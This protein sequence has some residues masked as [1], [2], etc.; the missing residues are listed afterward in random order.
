MVTKLDNCFFVLGTDTDV[1]KTYISS[2]LYKGLKKFGCGYFKAI[3]S[4]CYFENGKLIAPDV[5]EVCKKSDEDYNEDYILYR[6]KEAVS[7]HLA[8][9]MENIEIDVQKIKERY[10]L[11]KSKNNYL[12]VEGA[13][14]LLV[15]L[16]RDK[17]YIYDM[18]KLFDIPVILVCS[19]RVGAINHTLLTLE[20]LRNRGL[21]IQGIV[22]NRVNL[23]NNYEKDNIEIIKKLGR[24]ENTIIVREKQENII[25]EELINFLSYQS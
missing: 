4:G 5:L 19:T 17:F 14:G 10:E 2:L 13:G 7:P 1:G 16:I 15:P 21:R 3:Q 12:I 11:L 18:I 22:F 9:E 6:L 23:S 25:N 24:V 8:S 20:A